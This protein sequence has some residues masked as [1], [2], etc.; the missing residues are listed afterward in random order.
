M[1]H[2]RQG[3]HRQG[4]IAPAM[5][6]KALCG[7]PDRAVAAGQKGYLSRLL[8]GQEEERRHRPQEASG[9]GEI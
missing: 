4:D 2:L 6:L 7:H 9:H 1:P 5:L 3:I 8:R